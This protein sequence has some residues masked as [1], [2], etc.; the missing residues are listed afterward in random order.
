MYFLLFIYLKYIIDSEVHT[1]VIEHATD[2]FTICYRLKQ[3][4]LGVGGGGSETL[5]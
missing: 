5:R 1:H 4:I 3:D 2:F